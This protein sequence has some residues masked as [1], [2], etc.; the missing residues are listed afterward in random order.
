MTGVDESAPVVA[1]ASV[2]VDAP[3]ERVWATL[4][5]ID[6]WPDWNPDV[7]SAELHG[8]LEPGSEFTWKAGPGRIRST[9]TRVDG[10]T[11]I[12]WTGRTMGIRAAH[13]YHLEEGDSGVTIQT[14]ESWRG[15]LPRLLRPWMHKTLDRALRNGLDSAKRRC[16][17]EPHE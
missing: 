3:L 17:T 8:P 11:D 7:A 5:N 6:E 1:R 9:L 12:A 16:E 13:V 2:S 10:P 4:S 15:L 14:E